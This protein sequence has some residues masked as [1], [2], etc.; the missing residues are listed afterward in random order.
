[1]P[2]IPASAIHT[3]T[4][5]EGERVVVIDCTNCGDAALISTDAIQLPLCVHNAGSCPLLNLGT[6][7]LHDLGSNVLSTAS[8]G[9]TTTGLI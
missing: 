5:P 8:T 4:L 6:H 9:P 3:E 1:M 2:K 7:A